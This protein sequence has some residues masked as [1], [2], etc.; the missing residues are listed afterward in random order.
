M[1]NIRNLNPNAQ[2]QQQG[3]Q[4]TQEMVENADDLSCPSC[5]C[6]FISTVVNYKRISKFH[7]GTPQDALVPIPIHRCSDC[8]EI[9]DIEEAIKS[10]DKE[11]ED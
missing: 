10:L 7:L 5:G 1:A 11:K 9:F 6:V 2:P 8:G 4:I 3:P